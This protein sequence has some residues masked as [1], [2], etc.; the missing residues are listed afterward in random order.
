[1]LLKF[2]FS[3]ALFLT[4]SGGSKRGLAY[5]ATGNDISKALNSKASSWMYGWNPKPSVNTNI[6][7]VPMQWGSQDISSLWS[8]ILALDRRPAAV[9]GFNEPEMTGQSNISAE[10]AARL[11]K[12]YMLPLR[13]LGIRLCSPG[14]SS[15]PWGMPW[16]QNFINACP[17]CFD[18][19]VVHWYGDGSQWFKEYIQKVHA[20]FPTYPLWVTEYAS[21]SRDP[22]EQL[23]FMNDTMA[24]LESLSCV[25]RYSWFC[26]G[27]SANGLISNLLDSDGNLTPLG[28]SYLTS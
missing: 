7:F 5:S 11:W 6:S 14:I 4:A 20:T 24:F 18:V 23:R 15:A 19:M 26:Y 8:T 13:T 16:M 25:E 3:F 2:G 28:K 1:M 17:G 12:Q 21:T 27:R 10:E 22:Q 9:L